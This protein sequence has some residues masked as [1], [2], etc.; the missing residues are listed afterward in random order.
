MVNEENKRD[1]VDLMVKWKLSQGVAAQTESFAKGLRELVPLEYLKIFDAQELEWV[2]AGTPE[3]DIE[4]WKRNTVYWGG[5]VDPSLDTHHF[6]SSQ[7]SAPT[8]E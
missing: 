5:E 7:V 8:T 2:I 3:I 6:S 4:D 1:F